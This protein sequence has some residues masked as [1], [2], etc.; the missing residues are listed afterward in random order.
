VHPRKKRTSGKNPS[1]SPEIEN[2]LTFKPSVSE[3]TSIKI[4]SLLHCLSNP[5]F[6]LAVNFARE[7]REEKDGFNFKAKT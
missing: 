3:K 5:N 1:K 4:F 2:Y 7:R 6:L